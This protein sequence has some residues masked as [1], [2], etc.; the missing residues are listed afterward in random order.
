MQNDKILTLLNLRVCRCDVLFM[1][2]L[3]YAHVVPV[4]HS[5]LDSY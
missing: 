4:L 3:Q 1:M 2:L 5:L